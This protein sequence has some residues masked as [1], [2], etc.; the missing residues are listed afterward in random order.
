MP[1]I[2]VICGIS[3]FLLLILV[4][5]LNPFLAFMIVSISVALAVGMTVDKAV[6]SIQKGIG[7]TMGVIVPVLGFGAMLGKLV[8][9]S[10]AAQ[11]ITSRLV[12]N[13]GTRNIQ[14]SLMLAG[15]IVGIA[16]FYEIGF[17]IMIPL[18]FTIAASTGLPL[19]YVGLPM[20]ASLSVT[21]GFLP[22]HPAPTALTAMFNADL[23]KTLLY[24]LTIAVPSILVSGPFLA[25]FLSRVNAKPL[26]EFVNQKPLTD[27]EMPGFLTSLFSALLP[28]LLIT[29]AT[30]AGFILPDD[31]IVRKILGSIGN[32]V[33]AMLLSVLSAIYFLGIARGKSMTEIM[34]SLSHSVVSIAMIMLLISGAGSLKQVLVDGGV[35]DYIGGL[36]SQSALSPLF[37]GWLIAAVLRICIGSATVSGLTAAGIVLPLVTGTDVRPELMVLAVGSGSLICS[38]VNDTGFW[39]FKEYFNLSI[40]DTLKTW[41]IMET[42]IGVTGLAGVMILSLFVK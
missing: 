21:H 29:S 42:S 19:L 30:I 39:L 9:E 6:A 20:L 14:T 8:S 41:T 11:R 13:L 35:S 37:L 16:L 36:M 38:H 12:G 31:N 3:L 40:K 17:F 4:F 5:K 28:V 23:G 7:S 33:I 34:K 24:G 15:F 1:L 32:P 10:G 22:P 26:S 2:I 27:Q 18:V 25:K